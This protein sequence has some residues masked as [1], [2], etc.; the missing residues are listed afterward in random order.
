MSIQ[1]ISSSPDA[2]RADNPQSKFQQFRTDFEQLSNTLQAGN[3][4]GAQQA[5]NSLMQDVHGAD[6]NGKNTTLASDLASLGQ[7][8][9][10]GDLSAA[11][12]AFSTLQQ[13]MQSVGQAH[14]HRHRHRAVQSSQDP[15]ASGSILPMGLS[16][17]TSPDTQTSGSTV[18][19][20]A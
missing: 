18:S 3:L 11:Q 2:Y 9:Q 4:A 7:A 16:G 6:Q 14:H 17:D 19:I 1:P 20:K 8:L 15:S 5:Y 13:D 12:K 10:S